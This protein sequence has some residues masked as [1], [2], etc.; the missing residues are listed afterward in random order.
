MKW[1]RGPG[2][3]Q[4]CWV[5]K[6]AVAELEES[7]QG[8]EQTQELRKPSITE[9]FRTFCKKDIFFLQILNEIDGREQRRHITLAAEGLKIE[10]QSAELISIQFAMFN[11]IPE[12]RA[13]IRVAVVWVE[14]NFITRAPFPPFI[15]ECDI[16]C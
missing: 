1:V 3:G 13:S 12:S 16:I 6:G 5:N 14:D 11:H 15:A 10:Q 4:G 8:A 7:R 2:S 9:G